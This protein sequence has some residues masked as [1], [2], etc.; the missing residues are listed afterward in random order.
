MEKYSYICFVIN[1]ISK[2]P[3]KDSNNNTIVGI[4]KRELENNTIIDKLQNKIDELEN[5]GSKLQN[6]NDEI[7]KRF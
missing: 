2:V 5:N 1:P 6:E 7:K 4:L 3:I